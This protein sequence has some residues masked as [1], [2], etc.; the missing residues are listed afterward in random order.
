MTALRLLVDGISPGSFPAATQRAFQYGDG[1][2]ETIAVLDGAPCL[3]SYHLARLKEGCRRLRLAPPDPTSLYR[4]VRDICAGS[5]RGILKLYWTAGESER[6]YRRPAPDRAQRVLALH[7]W[8]APDVAEGWRIRTCRHRLCDSPELAGIKHLNRLDQVMARSEWDD[9]S[10]QEGLVRAQDGGVI[11]GTMSNLFV[12]SGGRLSTPSLERAGIA[13]VVRRLALDTAAALGQTV[14][15][16][17]HTMDEL[18]LA[19]GLYLTNSLI[20][21]VRVSQWEDMNFDTAR[22]EHTLMTAVRGL[23]FRADVEPC[24]SR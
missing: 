18:R 2:F 21:V 7:D 12:E 24:W 3:W 9:A 5:E 6:G 23:C 4:E 19:D 17:S 11:S 14:D 10:L 1:L 8:P 22:P 15:V 16:R 20:G 13:G